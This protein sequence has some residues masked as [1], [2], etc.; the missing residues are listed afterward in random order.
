MVA[1]KLLEVDPHEV[2]GLSLLVRQEDKGKQSSVSRLR[3]GGDNIK[4]EIE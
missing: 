4:L 2:V 1:K 3:S